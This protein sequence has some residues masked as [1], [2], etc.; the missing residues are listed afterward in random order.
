MSLMR[1]VFERKPSLPRYTSTW[2]VNI[3]LSYIRSLSDNALLPL[4]DLSHKLACPLMI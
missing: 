3:V 1:G 2:D 4:K